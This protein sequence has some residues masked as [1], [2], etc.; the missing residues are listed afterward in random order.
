[1]SEL[2]AEIAEVR[3]R[4][5]CVYTRAQ[6]DA[7]FDRLAAEI[8]ATLSGSNPLLVAVLVGGMYPAVQLGMRFGFPYQLDYAHATRYRGQLSGGA[9]QWRSEPHL[10]LAGRVVLVVDDILDEGFTLAQVM[11]EC[12]RLGAA[13]VLSAVLVRKIHARPTIGHADYYGLEVGDRY[14]FGCGMDYKEYFRGLPEIYA[15]APP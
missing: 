2:A 4:A 11:Q 7:A 1:M 14:V 13:Q 5:Q 12:A 15:V 10:P 9:V 3:A 6:V 8:G